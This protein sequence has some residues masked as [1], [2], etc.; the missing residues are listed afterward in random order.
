MGGTFVPPTP[1]Q[2]QGPAKE[3]KFVPPSPDQWEGPSKG[4]DPK[5]IGGFLGNTLSSAGNMA[6]QIGGAIVHPID[7][8]LGIAKLGLGALE[9]GVRPVASEV[10]RLAGWTGDPATGSPEIPK[11]D[12]EKQVDAL[13]DQYKQRYGGL[14]NVADTLY[15]DPV[16][17]AMDASM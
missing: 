7:T 9:K 13:I 4:G 2:W 16:G 1:D 17:A 12:E 3:D 10:N 11:T 5:T 14:Q 6:A 8:G 15:K